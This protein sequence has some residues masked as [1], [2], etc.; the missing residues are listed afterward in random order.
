MD[1]TEAQWS[2]VKGILPKDPVR[3]D[4]RGCLWNDRR[5]VPSD[6]PVSRAAVNA[7]HHFVKLRPSRLVRAFTLDKT[8]NNCEILILHQFCENSS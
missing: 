6:N 5:K 3:A 4:G 8:I 2:I 7:P 1:L